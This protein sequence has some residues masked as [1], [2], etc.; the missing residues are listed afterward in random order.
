LTERCDAFVALLLRMAVSK[1]FDIRSD[2]PV[3]ND[4]Y[5][6]IKE[7]FLPPFVK[8]GGSPIRLLLKP[9]SSVGGGTAVGTGLSCGVDSMHSVKRHLDYPDEDFRLT[10]LCINNVGA[11][12]D[13]YRLEGAEKVRKGLYARARKAAADLGL[14]LVE[15]DSNV[16]EA[17]HQ[18]HYFSHSF[19]SAFAILC[20]KK[21]WK[22]Y[23]YASSGVDYVTGFSL[24]GHL[25][26]PP[27]R[28]E[29]LTTDCL[30]TSSLRIYIEAPT[31]SR[32]DKIV[33]ISDF[34]YAQRYLTS[35]T[36]S[37]ENCC[38]CD[39]C[40]RNMMTLDSIDRLDRFGEV[41]DIG[42]YERFKDRYLWYLHSKRDDNYFEPVFERFVS[43]GDD[44]F[45]RVGKVFDAASE[46]DSAWKSG[47]PAK[48][49]SAF[50]ELLPYADEGE[51][52]AAFRVARS[53][54]SGRGA[55]KDRDSAVRYWKVSADALRDEVANGFTTSRIK[56]FDLLWSMEDESQYP[57]M[58]S[59]L[60]PLLEAGDMSAM[61]RLGRANRFGKGV[62]KDTEAALSLFRAATDKDPSW[63]PELCDMLLSTD[64]EECYKE[65]MSRCQAR[66]DRGSKY[67]FGYIA[68]MYRDGKGV[69]KDLRTAARW[70]RK[71]VN[72]K[73]EWAP[74]ELFDILWVINEPE[75]DR[76]LLG[77]ARPG[78]EAESIPFMGRLGRM[79]RY[80]R[81]VDQDLHIAVK[82]LSK[83]ADLD[84]SWAPDLCDAVTESD[85][86]EARQDLLARA[87]RLC[88]E[89]SRYGYVCMGRMCRDGTAVDRDPLAAAEWFRKAADEDMDS[90]ALELFDVLWS[91]EDREYNREMMNIAYRLADAGNSG[92]MG[93]LGNIYRFGRGVPKN[94]LMAERWMSKACKKEPVRWGKSLEAIREAIAKGQDSRGRPFGIT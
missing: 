74:L 58:I 18:N 64:D 24:K 50:S 34:V 10:H 30:S 32:F 46:F 36:T 33:E 57:E 8:N 11:F 19:T 78:A 38:R 31:V 72:A 35:C 84:P 44:D 87:S 66:V 82:W 12:N 3:S 69:E 43:K 81:G 4:L 91:L 68:R 71:A 21:L 93:R 25:S 59:L 53:F 65:A 94:L 28:Y 90:A 7:Q 23:F 62:P 40:I 86:E 67:A 45:V 77:L 55:P 83:A 56:L 37:F 80:G 26:F 9:A 15:T 14:P 48:M 42:L 89:G 54:N 85:M 6:N 17:L 22:Y 79:Y 41:Y 92:A 27:S 20:L 39:K 88:D 63:L 47:N 61:V 49:A 1:G 60:D 75:Y 70:M 13:I 2:V 73:L 52:H 76:G 16:D 29:L 5:Y 51:M